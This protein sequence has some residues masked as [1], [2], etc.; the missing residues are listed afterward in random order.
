MKAPIKASPFA[1]TVNAVGR[2]LCCVK[3]RMDEMTVVAACSNGALAV[4]RLCSSL[5]VYDHL[6]DAA[7]CE[8]H[9]HAYVL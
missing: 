7:L 6:V 1:Q 5:P 4:V 8:Y 2:L 9:G 3:G